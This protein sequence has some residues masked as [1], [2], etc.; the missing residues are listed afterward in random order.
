VL[1]VQGEIDRGPRLDEDYPIWVAAPAL[2]GRP[3]PDRG[4]APS[5]PERPPSR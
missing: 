2:I 4:A 3:G 5:S 1:R